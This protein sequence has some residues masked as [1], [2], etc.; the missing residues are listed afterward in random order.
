MWIYNISY[1][2]A[3]STSDLE[4]NIDKKWVL[5]SIQDILWKLSD[6]MGLLITPIDIEYSSFLSQI[7]DKNNLPSYIEYKRIYKLVWDKVQEGIKSSLQLYK[8]DLTH[9]QKMNLILF[10][11][12]ESL[13]LEDFEI[14]RKDFKNL[15]LFWD[16]R[17]YQ[18]KR[19]IDVWIINWYTTLSTIEEIINQWATI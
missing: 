10:Y 3:Q 19:L 8:N 13:N 2:R 17:D 5:Q 14:L 12:H 1:L 7:R 4:T 9:E 18:I 6:K 16:N 11:T 15:Q